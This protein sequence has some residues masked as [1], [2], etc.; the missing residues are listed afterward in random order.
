MRD[1]GGDLESPVV[2]VE[3]LLSMTDSS[4]CHSQIID[5]IGPLVSCMCDD[6]ER[7]FFGSKKYWHEA[8]TR[9]LGSFIK[10]F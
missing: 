4:E 1:I 5:N 8:I 9:F 2:W 7:K 3:L 10:C 6:I